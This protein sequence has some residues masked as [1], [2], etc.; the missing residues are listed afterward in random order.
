M[1][2]REKEGGLQI[3]VKFKCWEKNTLLHTCAVQKN[4]QLISSTTC[5]HL[6][7]KANLFMFFDRNKIE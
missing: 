1:W 4:K 6:Y 7:T 5:A 3:R 2:E